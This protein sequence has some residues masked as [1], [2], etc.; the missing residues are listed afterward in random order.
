MK[1]IKN[2]L[3]NENLI[4][5]SNKKTSLKIEREP[6]NVNITI[7]KFQWEDED[8]EDKDIDLLNDL[9][10]DM[11]YGILYLDINFE[12]DDDKG[13]ISID[14]EFTRR[15]DEIGVHNYE[16]CEGID[17]DAI[18]KIIKHCGDICDYDFSEYIEDIV[19]KISY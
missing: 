1:D 5:E 17:K 13:G 19:K 9:S 10:R 2:Y 6:L 7:N 4:T 12:T 11:N 18:G 15:R 8:D 14:I 16:E 3:I